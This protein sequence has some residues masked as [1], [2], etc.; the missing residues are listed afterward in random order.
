MVN[1]HKWKVRL[2]H[3]ILGGLLVHQSAA[4]VFPTI[5]LADQHGT[6]EIFFEVRHCKVIRQINRSPITPQDSLDLSLRPLQHTCT[7]ADP[8]SLTRPTRSAIKTA[9][10]NASKITLKTPASPLLIST[11]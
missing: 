11:A 10:W 1:D 9:L 2:Q 4:G 3:S 8:P 5:M 6:G 7:F